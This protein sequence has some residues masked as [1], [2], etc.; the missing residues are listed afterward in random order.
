MNQFFP[1]IIY[2]QFFNLIS[3]IT[4]IKEASLIIF[5]SALQ[6]TLLKSRQIALPSGNLFAHDVLDPFP[7]Y[8]RPDPAHQRNKSSA[9]SGFFADLNFSRNLAR[10]ALR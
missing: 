4:P 7:L 6:I 9:F 8:R 5:S 3:E 1:R 10:I 2:K